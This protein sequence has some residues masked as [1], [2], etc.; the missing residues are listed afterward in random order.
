MT[1]ETAF[2]DEA[3]KLL[4]L[5]EE[6]KKQ[7][8]EL[9]SRFKTENSEP[10]IPIHQTEKKIKDAG[11]DAAN[12]QKI[13]AMETMADG[14]AHDLNNILAGIVGY[15]E[16][17]QML[18]GGNK[19]IFEIQGKVLDTCDRAKRLIDQVLSFSRHNY[20]PHDEE[21]MQMP[22]VIRNV[23][24]QL[25]NTHHENIR[26]KESIEENSGLIKA[27][28]AM[29]HQIIFNICTNAAEAMKEKGGTL[30]VCLSTLKHER[31]SKTQDSKLEPGH[32]IKIS[33]SD[34]GPGIPEEIMDKIFDPYFTTKEKGEGTGLGL[35]VVHGVV[36]N[37]RGKITV[38]SS[39]GISTVFEIMLPLMII[40][41]NI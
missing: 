1:P 18:A 7:L 11:T 34:T 40:P 39:P 28:P 38:N 6:Q 4:N 3:G 31:D 24:K 15:S 27:S 37:Y 26:I 35:S 22:P 41:D 9:Y 25:E 8:L 16:V 10:E 33:I 12:S 32:Y 19:Q 5:N 17:A 23:L 14:L 13:E 21:L 29:M 36:K 20:Q 2:I 30:S